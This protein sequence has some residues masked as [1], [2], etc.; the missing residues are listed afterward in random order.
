MPKTLPIQMVRTRGSQ[1]VFKK[2]AS[3]SNDIPNWI[4]DKV[5]RKNAKIIL[6]RLDS[7]N[8]LFE[9]KEASNQENLPILLTAYLYKLATAKSHR[10]STRSIFNLRGKP[11]IIGLE[12]I[13]QLIVKIEN[14]TDLNQIKRNLNGYNTQSMSKEK[15]S[16]IASIVDLK[17]FTPI[18]HKDDLIGKTVKVKLVDYQKCNSSSKHNKRLS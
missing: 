4:T 2:E 9:E 5:V 13:N 8:A 6:E 1:D 15:R 10:K 16:G 17:L 18:M 3:G 14:R 12:N 11:N 7:L